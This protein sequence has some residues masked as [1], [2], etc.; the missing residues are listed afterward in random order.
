MGKE[1]K[2]LKLE[3]GLKLNLYKLFKQKIIMRGQSHHASI[4]W[5]SRND[6]ELPIIAT[7]SSELKNINFGCLQI[8]GNFGTQLI[9]LTAAPRHFGGV[10]WYFLC[11]ITR[12]RASV[13]WMLPGT[14]RFQS[15]QSFGRQ[16]AYW[17]QSQTPV[18]RAIDLSR[19]I[20]LQLGGTE[21]TSLYDFEPV[22]PRGMH[23][24][25]FRSKIAT[26]QKYKFICDQYIERLLS[27]NGTL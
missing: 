26:F 17:S 5:N 4:A 13:L 6:T 7:I 10:Q 8:I 24:K 27:P 9:E 23:W 2:R 16:V 18:D 22:K 3:Y 25:T 21:T 19:D 12:Q 1:C 15:R 11:P 20:C 14:T